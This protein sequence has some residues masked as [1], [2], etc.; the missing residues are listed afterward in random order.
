MKNSIAIAILTMTPFLVHA[1]KP[2]DPLASFKKIV[3]ACEAQ[4]K[5]EPP[6]A[7][8]QLKNGTWARNFWELGSI[9]HDVKRSDS[10][11]SPFTAYIRVEGLEQIAKRDTEDEARAA[12][13]QDTT[14]IRGVDELRYAFQDSKWK[15][16]GGST[17]RAM[18]LRGESDFKDPLGKVDVT[19]DALESNPRWA[20]C[21]P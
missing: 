14:A 2:Q 16:I 21:I 18:R 8:K 17:Q 9:S 6:T 12:D 10:L 3:A 7:I 5:K 11:V 19:A 15:L 20:R 13:K 1:Q 4:L